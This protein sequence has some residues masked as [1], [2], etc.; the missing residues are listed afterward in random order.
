MPAAKTQ[1]LAP[2]RSLDQ[3]MDA[4]KRANDVRVRRAKLKKDL[5]DGRVRIVREGRFPKF[6][7]H[8]QHVTFNGALAAR[9]G[10]EVWYI[11]ERAVFR[12][13]TEGL[14]L[15]EVAPGIDV[16]RDIRAKLGFPLRTAPYVRPMDA[17][18]FRAERMG[19][20]AE[21]LGQAE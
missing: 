14:L 17:R 7:T 21:W 13:T 11:T 1:A 16:E 15:V 12:L 8:A 9:Q 2:V 18:L 6:V 4:L 3:R 5:K 20:A 19:V 10:Q